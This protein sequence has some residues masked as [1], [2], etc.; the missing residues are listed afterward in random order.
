MAAGIRKKSE[1]SY[2]IRVKHDNKTYYA[3]ARTLKEAEKKRVDLKY[4]LVHGTYVKPSSYT[5]GEWFEQWMKNYK[6]NTVKAG[7]YDTYLT[8][9]DMC[10]KDVFGS[11][12]LD[13]IKGVDIQ[14]FYN[15]LLEKLYI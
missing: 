14:R 13:K 12:K 6:K 11:V 9:Y 5:Y 3:Y 10:I 15:N 7:T 1:N 8:Y 2:E 4:K